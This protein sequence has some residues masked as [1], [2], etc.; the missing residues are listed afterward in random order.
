LTYA[1]M[2]II[3]GN[4]MDLY[5]KTPAQLGAAIKARRTQL[6][7]DQGTLAN[8]ARVSRNWLMQLEK[9]APGAS[10][11]IILRVLGPLKMSL[12][13]ESPDKA[14]TTD[15]RAS[16]QFSPVDINQVIQS[17]KSTKR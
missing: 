6:G 16:A 5:L 11:G 10:I 8:R 14:D 7:I 1:E 4:P 13:L 15:Q 17:L 9:G 12:S 2:P 3:L